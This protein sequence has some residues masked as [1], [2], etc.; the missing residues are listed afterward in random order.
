MSTYKITG[1]LLTTKKLPLPGLKVS[2]WAKD[3]KVSDHLGVA[4]SDAKGQFNISFEDAKFFDGIEDNLPDVF[5]L[6]YQGDRVIHSTEGKPIKNGKDLKNVVLVIDTEENTTNNE[7][8]NAIYSLQGIVEQKENKKSIPNIKVEAWDK[9]KKVSDQLGL[10]ITDDKGSFYI[11]YDSS[12]FKDDPTDHLP[13]V[14]FRI[15]EGE[16]MIHSTEGKPLKNVTRLKDIRIAIDY[17]FEASNLNFP[18]LSRATVLDLVKNATHTPKE[19]KKKAPKI[20]AALKTKAQQELQRL[21]IAFFEKASYDLKHYAKKIDFTGLTQEDDSATDYMETVIDKSN[22]PNAIKSEAHARLVK[23]KNAKTLNEL[24]KPD[25]AIKDNPLIEKEKQQAHVFKIAE[26]AALNPKIADELIKKDIS[27]YTITPKAIDELIKENVVT[28]AEGETLQLN[29][30]VYTLAKGNTQLSNAIKNHRPNQPLTSI[31]DLVALEVNDWKAILTNAQV[32][33][34][35]AKI[36]KLAKIKQKQIE[37]LYP[38]QVFMARSK[39]WE[40]P[41]VQSLMSKFYA[42]NDTLDVLHLNYS[43]DSKDLEALNMNNFSEGEKTSILENLKTNQ[44]LYNLTKDASQALHLKKRYKSGREIIHSGYYEFKH[45]TGFD[46]QT[47]KL[48][49][50]NAETAAM[51]FNV[52]FIDISDKINSPLLGSMIGG[53]TREAQSYLRRL[54]GYEDFFGE[55]DFCKCKHCNSIISP[56][57]YF[58]DLMGFLKENVLDKHFINPH[59][60]SILNPKVRRPDLWSELV[61]NCE[62][63]H[64]LIPYL[65][66]INEVL[67]NFIY[68]QAPET[69]GLPD[70]RYAIENFVYYLL[71]LEIEEEEEEEEGCF[72]EMK[73]IHQPFHLP[74]TE[75][76]IY[77]NHF[78]ITRES[79]ARIHF[80]DVADAENI[81]PQAVLGVSKCAYALISENRYADSPGSSTNQTFLEG[82][83]GINIPASGGVVNFELQ[84]L[85]HTLDLE[86]EEFTELLKVQYVFPDT[87]LSPRNV[88]IR[89]DRKEGALQINVEYIVGVNQGHLDKMHRFVRLYKQLDWSLTELDTINFAIDQAFNRLGSQYLYLEQITQLVTLQKTHNF[90]VDELRIFIHTMPSSV[91]NERFNISS[92]IKEETDRWSASMLSIGNIVFQ[93]PNYRVLSSDDTSFV[94]K[95]KVH[96]RLLAGLGLNDEQ[97]FHLIENLKSALSASISTDTLGKFSVTHTNLSILYRHV[98]LLKKLKLSVSELFFFIQHEST[99]S[100]GYLSNISEIE[101]VIRLIE[102]YKK[103][104]YTLTDLQIILENLIPQGLNDVGMNLFSRVQQN[105][106][107]L[108]ADTLFSFAEGISEAQSRRIIEDNWTTI[109]KADLKKFS[110][111]NLASL[112][113]T[114]PPEIENHLSLEQQTKVISRLVKLVGEQISGALEPISE[115]DLTKINGIRNEE[116]G[117][118]ESKA[119]LD[120][121][122]AIFELVPGTT[123]KYQLVAGVETTP[124]LLGINIPNAIWTSLTADQ[125]A[126]LYLNLLRFF[127]SGTPEFTDRLWVGIAGLNLEQ[128]RE[129]ILENNNFFK[130]IPSENLYWLTP[131]FE[132]DTYINV[133]VDIPLPA[134]KAQEMLL[135]KHASQIIP[136]LLAAHF[137]IST[138]KLLTLA[139]L[140]G[141]N[142]TDQMYTEM[143]H[144]TEPLEVLETQIQTI[145]KL[146]VWFKDKVFTSD[147]LQ[148]IKN[149]SGNN[150][151]IFKIDDLNGFTSPR[152]SNLQETDI[153]RNLIKDAL[154]ADTYKN[155]IEDNLEEDDA[156]HLILEGYIFEG[157][158]TNPRPRFDETAILNLPI[159]LEAEQRMLISL[160][161]VILFPN[162][163]EADVN[164]NYSL[165]ALQKFKDVLHLVRYLG[166]SPEVIP[167]FVSNDFNEIALATTS[168]VTAIRTKY[169]TEAEW[170]EKIGPFEDKIRERKRDALTD[171]LIHTYRFD[172]PDTLETEQH[173][174]F[175]TTHDLYNY[176]LIDTELEGCA[177]TSRVVA[178]ISSL[179]LYIQRCLLNLEQNEEGTIHVKPGDIP[180]SQWQWRKNYRVWEANRKVF[181]YP[182]NYIEPDLRDNKTELF[183]E[184]ESTLLQQDINTQNA[185][186]AYKKYMTGFDEISKL[187]IAG[188]YHH[189]GNMDS[190]SLEKQADT[191]HLFGVTASDPPLYYYR[192]IENVYKKEKDSNTYSVKYN[193]WEKINLQIPVKKV[194]PIIY[195]NTLHLFW[196][197]IVTRPKTEMIDGSS[198]FS[199]YEHKMTVKFSSLQLDGTWQTPQ[200]YNYE[201][202]IFDEH[203]DSVRDPLVEPIEISNWVISKR[204]VIQNGQLVAID[205]LMTKKKAL[206]QIVNALK[207]DP[208]LLESQNHY[209]GKI[210]ISGEEVDLQNQNL[211]AHDF[212][213][214][215]LPKY[216]SKQA[217]ELVEFRMLHLDPKDEYTLH[218]DEWERIYPTALNINGEGILNIDGKFFMDELDFRTS[219]PV[220]SPINQNKRLTSQQLLDTKFLYVGYPNLH[221]NFN[222]IDRFSTAQKLLVPNNALSWRDIRGEEGFPDGNELMSYGSHVQGV[223]IAIVNGTLTDAIITSENELFFLHSTNNAD[224]GY[225]IKRL[226]T[227]LNK[228]LN[229]KIH[230]YGL[231][232]FLSLNFQSLYLKEKSFEPEFNIEF[233]RVTN[234]YSNSIGEMSTTGSLGTYFREMFFHIPYLIANHLNSQNKF[235]EAQQWYHYIFN[236][237]GN[238]LQSEKDELGLI[239]DSQKRKRIMANR[240]WQFIEFRKHSL[241]TW[242]D[243][244]NDNQAIS[245]YENDPFNPH[246]IARLRL[247]AYMK[248]ITMKYIDNLL[249]WGDHLFAQDTMESISEATLL[250][251]MASEILGPKPA[252][253]GECEQSEDNLTYDMIYDEMNSPH[254]TN[255]LNGVENEI[256]KPPKR[257][258]DI[259]P[260]V[261]GSDILNAERN[262]RFD[263]LKNV[264]LSSQPS[265]DGPDLGLDSELDID[266]TETS[267]TSENPSFLMNFD[268]WGSWLF[269][270]S[271]HT[272][273]L[274]QVCQFCI[275]PNPDLLGYWDRVADRLF[276]IRN[277]MNFSGVR[278]QISLFAPEIDPR[279]LVRAKAA[280]LSLDEVLNSIQGDLPPYRFAFL[281]AKAKEYAGALQGFGGALLGSLEKKS[282]E[283]LTMMRLG[284]QDEILKMTRHLRNMEVSASEA[285]LAGLRIRKESIEYRKEYYKSLLEIGLNSWESQSKINKIAGHVLKQGSII[286]MMFST[287]LRLVP[288]IVGFS[289]STPTDG[290]ANAGDAFATMM[291]YYGSLADILS[292]MQS[293]TGGEKRREQSWKFSL[294]QTKNELK[295][296]EKQLVAAEIRKDIS[297]KSKELHEKSIEQ[298]QETYEFYRDRFTNYGL[299]TWL[300]TQLQGMFRDSYNNAMTLARMAERAYRFERNDDTAVLL[301]GNYWEASKS[302]LMAG[303]KLMNDLRKMELRYMETNTRSMEVDQAFSLTQ[304]DPNALLNLKSTGTCE[305]T[306]PELYFDLFYPG[307]YRRQIKS[308]RLTIPCITG[309]YSNVSAVMTLKESHIRKEAKLPNSEGSEIDS[310]LTLVPPSRTTSVATSTAQNDSGVFRLDFRDERYMPFEGAG[311]VESTWQI[312]LP[313]T[314]RPF[315]YSTINDCI[316]HIS[317]TA[318][319]DTSFRESVEEKE[320]LLDNLLKS[321]DFSLPRVFSLRQEFSQAFHQLLHSSLNTEVSL[322]LSEKHFPLFVQ[323]KQLAIISA[324][325]IVELDDNGFRDDDGEVAYPETGF[326]LNIQGDSTSGDS[327]LIDGWSS[328][329]NILKTD[330]SDTIFTPRVPANE[331]FRVSFQVTDGDTFRPIT[332]PLVPSDSSALDD[333][334]IKDVYLLINYKIG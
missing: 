182:E 276:K 333:H 105:N 60:K 52:N 143:L 51:H 130:E 154:K 300:S 189:L 16:D 207:D 331:P 87:F 285:G 93:H 10:T 297:I 90:T 258:F 137:E 24:I 275:P 312:E 15:Y 257:R 57:A 55:T 104:D 126:E 164:T 277:C 35:E 267:D 235:S 59:H 291:Q 99:I 196:V 183:K 26:L 325:L 38:N 262:A 63:T 188:S 53:T 298:H 4:Y 252:E 77:L 281:L 176:F 80:K 147:R 70:N 219:T 25:T 238:L 128:S 125:R 179:Q 308:A 229:D 270:P 195:Q 40:L 61:L 134:A 210:D 309:P 246:A 162:K 286:P 192:T 203:G 220:I 73:S 329:R 136:N 177:R 169:D 103:S 107:L 20:Y 142:Y 75:L 83:Y 79:V 36:E 278:R 319:Y 184:L 200:K 124:S 221:V 139:D 323:G 44:N 62:N 271:Y 194:S 294:D 109:K 121:N 32:N 78:P 5:F 265:F 280:G 161:N 159:I 33:S 47:A 218:G 96:H 135:S 213:I 106:S 202:P 112:A 273:F 293:I 318:E 316:L 155:L 201:N 132:V 148:F 178:G 322:E 21:T 42:S 239:T 150:T 167:L 166:V 328:E 290:T 282:A 332:N 81:I 127:Q 193:N 190:D 158:S 311:A 292:Q 170:Q 30:N 14:F 165:K 2:V 321:D 108:F 305:F 117:I 197:E 205:D 19:L 111:R 97:F 34:D 303:E 84:Q 120:A 225:I 11:Q 214:L 13:D 299:Y 268:L 131:G 241:A 6:V 310:G 76:E 327:I 157:T 222:E 256:Q 212:K 253:L 151:H 91:L 247:G 85:L 288:S 243:Q 260:T 171:Y 173:H 27:L 146:A 153:Y 191:L 204:G 315:D 48:I 227:S 296:I 69:E 224:K 72:L 138:E 115:L 7:P 206:L 251:S 68:T 233:N 272:S 114:I 216:G 234:D 37:L 145:Q 67:E 174:W 186:D 231:S 66:I 98:L 94:E 1:Q 301:N 133:P 168:V 232:S 217:H 209:I 244:L 50:K 163:D 240:V 92:F 140:V 74:L 284:Q 110:V 18:N 326:A 330:V 259:G 41:E 43:M 88:E 156:L 54:N 116:G 31:S 29:A 123:D 58:V 101:K 82:F 129:L 144:G 324:E 237:A 254:C 122:S 102:W 100:D 313:K 264:E 3:K 306:V 118:N 295:E 245:A 175:Q 208:G 149:H 287:T 46:E 317:Y 86:R 119:I 263:I 160:N 304:I 226:G 198:E 152:L 180:K 228:V 242:K 23:W 45:N 95:S 289:M 250:Y 28:K 56:A 8:A 236:P 307:Q 187:K 320:G 12:R 39:K 172:D 302:G 71:S 249:D 248:N 64:T 181:L 89:G 261:I 215:L 9:D 314:F 230:Q 334:K 49:Y 266:F 255:F 279:L 65:T 141:Y 223:E 211:S 269:L 113:F 17:D 283:E 274:K 22:L 185:E 199:G